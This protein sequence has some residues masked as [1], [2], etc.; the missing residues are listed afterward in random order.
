MW[1]LQ[2]T[3]P[4]PVTTPP[5]ELAEV[6]VSV[7][8]LLASVVFRLVGSRASQ[9]RV[10]LESAE[11]AVLLAIIAPECMEGIC[12]AILN[13]LATAQAAGADADIIAGLAC[14][15][16]MLVSPLV[17]LLLVLMSLSSVSC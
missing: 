3:E 15:L 8:P 12:G 17:E 14:C 16:N 11:F 13:A 4:P 1:R 7:T 2:A 10:S 6:A 9:H 5:A